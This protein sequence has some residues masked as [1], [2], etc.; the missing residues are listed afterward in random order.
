METGALDRDRLYELYVQ[1]HAK[2]RSDVIRANRSLGSSSPEKS[3]LEILDRPAFDSI[4]DGTTGEPEMVHRFVV[5]V[6]RGHEQEFPQ[7]RV[8]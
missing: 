4:V 3:W 8:A 5:R 2:L 7:L 1:Y 6:I